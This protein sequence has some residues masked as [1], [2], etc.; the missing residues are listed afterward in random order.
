MVGNQLPIEHDSF[1]LVND[2]H[3]NTRPANIILLSHVSQIFTVPDPEFLTGRHSQ[4]S[5]NGIKHNLRGICIKTAEL[6]KKKITQIYCTPYWKKR[7][8][9]LISNMDIQI[10]QIY[11]AAPF[12]ACGLAANTI[13]W[14]WEMDKLY[15]IDVP[16]LVSL[17]GSKLFISCP[18][19]YWVCVYLGPNC[20]EKRLLT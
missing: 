10:V 16:C 3:I 6:V 2:V 13:H 1:D 19:A 14:T 15:F 5:R 7:D 12:C 4:R 9:V 17:K 11:T 8:V 20:K 18:K